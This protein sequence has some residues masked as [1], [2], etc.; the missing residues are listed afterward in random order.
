MSNDQGH[1]QHPST[2]CVDLTK[3]Y[4]L[5]NCKDLQ[6][7]Q[8]NVVL[9]INE[10]SVTI[11]KGFCVSRVLVFNEDILKAC[12]TTF[13]IKTQPVEILAIC[14]KKHINFYYSD[15]KLETL[16]VPFE[17]VR[18]VCYE[19][20]LVLQTKAELYL[21]N[22][23]FELKFV[24]KDTNSAF[25][26]NE[27]ICSF[28]QR[29]SGIALCTTITETSI[30]V[31]HIKNSSRSV[32]FNSTS[33]M[34]TKPRKTSMST[35]TTA[36]TTASTSTSRNHTKPPKKKHFAI[37]ATPS[38]SKGMEHHLSQFIILEHRTSTLLSEARISNPNELPISRLRK[39]VILS[40][41][42]SING[43]R[44]NRNHNF[45]KIFTVHFEYQEGIVV[46]SK[47]KQ[48]LYVFKYDSYSKH[49]SVYKCA[50]LD[51]IPLESDFAGNLLVLTESGKTFIV[52]P[53]LNMRSSCN[54]TNSSIE[55]LLSSNDERV[56]FKTH[57]RNDNGSESFHIVKLVMKPASQLVF[58]CLN[59]FKYLSGSTTNLIIWMLWRSAYDSGS[60]TE[61]DA[62]VIALLA[63]IFPFDNDSSVPLMNENPITKLISRALKLRVENH[64]NNSMGELAPYIAISLHILREEFRLDTTK[65]EYMAL[66]GSLLC[67]LTTWMGWSEV[68]PIYYHNDDRNKDEK[69]KKEEKV[70]L[71][72]KMKKDHRDYEY[73]NL[74]NVDKTTRILLPQLL[75]QP[76]NLLQ[77]LGS[78]FTGKILPYVTFSQL[79]EE[80]ESVDAEVTPLTHSILKLYEVLVS[81]NYGPSTLVDMMSEMGITSLSTFPIGVSFPLKE[82]LLVAQESPTY[83]WSLSSLNL[84]RRDDLTQLITNPTGAIHR[85]VLKYKEFENLSIDS[86]INADAA[87]EQ[88]TLWDDQS[89]AKRLEITKLMFDEDRRFYEITTLLHQTKTQTAYLKIDEDIGEYDLVLVQRS[90]AVVVA[91]RTLTIPMGRAALTYGGRE[92]I[93]TERF[94]V[95]K[96]NLNSLIYPMMT[97]IVHSEDSIAA[98]L[99]EWGHFHNGVSSGLSISREAKGISGSWIAFNKPPGELNAQHAGFLFGLGL[100]GHLKKLEEWHIYNYLRPKDPLTSAG[101]LMGMAASL[102]GTMDNKLTKVLSVHA[103]ALLP[104]GAK[105]LNV[106]TMVQTAGFMGIG[107]LYLET[108]HRRMSEVLLSQI[109]GTVQQR[110]VAEVHEGY[111]LASGLALGLV[112]LGKGDD[113]RGLNDTHVVDRLMALAL[114]LNNTH[115]VQEV[116]KS[117][118]GAIMALCLIYLKTENA[119]VANKLKIP[120][121]QPML[122]FIRPDLLFLRCL[123]VSLI[124][125]ST[126]EPSRA[127]VEQQ[128]PQ[129]VISEF[130]RLDGFRGGAMDSDLVTYLNIMGG[131]C[132]SIALKFASSQN[133]RAKSTILYYLDEVM[134]LT[135]KPAINYDQKLT[136]NT[137]ITIQN[138]LALC[139]SVIMSASGDLEV[140]QRLR[141]LYNDTSKKMGFGGYMAINTALGF[142]F[143]GGGQMAFNVNSLFGIASLVIS[144]YPIYP[145]ENSEYDVHLQAMRHFWALAIEQRCLV[146]KD[147]KSR[148][149]CK[150][151][152]LIFM[153]NGKVIQRVTPCLLPNLK[154]VSKI[155]TQSPEHFQVEID[156]T[157]RSQMLENFE[158]TMTLYVLKKQN[159]SIL[160]PNLASLLKRSNE[161]EMN[162]DQIQTL[163]NN[164]LKSKV[165]DGMMDLRTN[166][167]AW[168]NAMDAKSLD[169]KETNL[170]VFNIIE[171]RLRIINFARLATSIEDIWNLR[172]ILEFVDK[173]QSTELHYIPLEFIQ[174]LK[175][176]LNANIATLER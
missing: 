88:V 27:Q 170:S 34:L 38:I 42:E 160:E 78:L 6:L 124:M 101:L 1:H 11:Y 44:L 156:C 146:V 66:L 51:C 87:N 40:K 108:Q 33:S 138:V 121:S 144:L 67:Q 147:E 59:S 4:K 136:Y 48:E 98:E 163:L 90:L 133:S 28:S 71:K 135:S 110:D 99:N 122:E 53:F 9:C 175:H 109:T 126:I 168:E 159:Y 174:E 112:N 17:I 119:N 155:E 79:V 84:T 157:L 152:V 62:M 10:K 117:C 43:L 2:P 97:N 123:T 68:W 72:T 115:A 167:L 125:W 63:L 35:S 154:E 52:N 31:Y 165:F 149:P 74:F 19:K 80:G 166:K 148:E 171:D 15:G 77:S 142:L 94:P 30:N 81:P 92:P 86:L 41:I 3:G 85:D 45:F 64:V 18:V 131:A 65:R 130:K 32:R 69:M 151:P 23:E 116:N 139:A 24:D 56:S 173:K 47:L 164:L 162:E 55:A 141:V 145:K 29:D 46:V 16:N 7:C 20:G 39:D 91:L 106:P 134:R 137:A 129:V 75:Q 58:S 89:E 21:V 76:P 22:N 93:L 13:Y 176:I 73:C 128:F 102:R 60:V 49:H 113:L 36:S 105:D 132:L 104:R 107:L 12:M 54:M 57:N 111:R 143:L 103:V 153:R 83:D 61:W 158:K 100:N 14:F 82:V 96:F 120:E 5:K 8:N 50:C 140:F 70:T 127:W 169:F 37:P 172:L 118:C 95:A 114:S 25:S 150:I 26:S 161:N